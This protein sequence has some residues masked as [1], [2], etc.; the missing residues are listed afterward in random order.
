MTVLELKGGILDMVSRIEDR[1]TLEVFY[2]KAKEFLLSSD[3]SFAP[4]LQP[5]Q[6][7][8]LLLAIEESQDE[9]EL[10]EHEE[11]RK[12]HAQWLEK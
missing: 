5:G 4:D 6:R 3:E 2:E 7:T 11:V 10:M 1:E 8:E 12:Q 9:A